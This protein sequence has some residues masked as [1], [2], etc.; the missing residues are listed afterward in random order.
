MRGSGGGW[1]EGDGIM[2]EQGDEIGEQHRK[3]KEGREARETNG[4]VSV[5]TVLEMSPMEGGQDRRERCCQRPA[6]LGPLCGL[7]LLLWLKEL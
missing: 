3:R 6:Q 7:R 2:E 4:S 1:K 5:A